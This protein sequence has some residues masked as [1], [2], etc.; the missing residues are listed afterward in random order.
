MTGPDIGPA[1]NADFRQIVGDIADFRGSERRRGQDRART[2]Q[3][4]ALFE[5]PL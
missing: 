5:K 3:N 2:G 1:S 4:L